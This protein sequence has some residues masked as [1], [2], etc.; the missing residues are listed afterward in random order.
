MGDQEVEMKTIQVPKYVDWCFVCL[1]MG[2]YRL[3]ALFCIDCRRHACRDHLIR[4]GAGKTISKCFT[5]ANL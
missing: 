5:H 2:E 1:A 3:T 4:L